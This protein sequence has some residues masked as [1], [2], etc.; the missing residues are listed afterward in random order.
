MGAQEKQPRK[1]PFAESVVMKIAES[2]QKKG[3]NVTTD[4]FFISLELA[5]KLQKEGTSR[6]RIVCTNSKHFPKK[7]ISYVK[8]E[9][10]GSIFNYKG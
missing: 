7:I 3:Y 2:V 6:V 9:K 10:Y 1:D 4:N 8:G 5:K